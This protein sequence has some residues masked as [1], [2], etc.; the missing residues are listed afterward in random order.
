MVNSD[1]DNA[2]NMDF[3][4]EYAKSLKSAERMIADPEATYE[5][6]DDALNK[7]Q[8]IDSTALQNVLD[9]LFLMI[10]LVRDWM[11]GS[12]RKI[13]KRAIVAILGAIIYF[14]M[15]V[16]AIPDFLPGIGYIDDALVIALV[17][18]SIHMDLMEYKQWKNSE[19]AASAE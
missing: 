19:A 15:P 14:V 1:R 8:Q 2:D 18:K 7:A 12:Y 11:S 13:P 5:Q 3:N 9:D 16:D 4:R 6:L 10:S 17:I